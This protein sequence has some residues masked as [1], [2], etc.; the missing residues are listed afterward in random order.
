MDDAELQCKCRGDRRPAHVKLRGEQRV[1]GGG[2]V[3]LLELYGRRGTAEDKPMGELAAGLDP[4][5]SSRRP[6]RGLS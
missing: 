1:H 2:L 3:A 6:T 4:A 5:L